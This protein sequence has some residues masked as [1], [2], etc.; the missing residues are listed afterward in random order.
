MPEHLFEVTFK[1]S[2][3]LARASEPVTFGVPLARGVLNDAARVQMTDAG[4][5]P[6]LC[7]ATPLAQWPDG[8]IKWMLV[9]TQVPVAAAGEALCLGQL[10]AGE[11]SAKAT[12]KRA[13]VEVVST[14]AGLSIKTG[15]CQ[16][17]LKSGG[18]LELG[19]CLSL[20]GKRVGAEP[21]IEVTL[22]DEAGK[23]CDAAIE[24]WR[25]ELHNRLRA[26]I[27]YE[28]RFTSGGQKLP[29]RYI[30]RLHFFAGLGSV[31]AD[32]TLWNP[33]PAEHPGGVWDL[34][35]KGS[36]YFKELSLK[37]RLQDPST[38]RYST[39]PGG[40]L[41]DSSR[42]VSV[43]QEASGGEN[44][45]SRNHLNRHGETPLRF[46]GYEVRSGGN[47]IERGKRCTPAATLANDELAVSA[48]IT[49]FWQ[50]FPKA[51]EI[52]DDTLVT[53]LFPG[54]FPDNF[55]LQGGE[56][57][58]HTVYFHFGAGSEVTGG[59]LSW[60]HAPLLP[61]LS[62]QHYFASG[63]CPK[64]VP[65][66]VTATDSYADLWQKMVNV[67]IEPG[68]S[69]FDRR[70]IIDEYGWRNFGDLY[71]DH[72][73]V[74]HKGSGEFVSHYNNQYDVIKGSLIQFMR[75][76]EPAWFRLAGELARHVMDIDI[77]HTE[78]DRY[79]YNYGLFWHTDHHLDA[80]TGSHRT[81]SKKHW[82]S[83]PRHL[84]G[85]G[86]APAHN[87][88]T[89]LLYYHWLTG[90]PMA[91]ECVLSLARFAV[92]GVNGPDKVREAAIEKA[93]TIVKW[94]RGK[95][96]PQGGGFQQVYGLDGPGRGS[97]NS[98]QVLLDAY[99]LSSEKRY[100]DQAER[101]IR[102][103][104]SPDDD[105]EARDLLNAEI[106]WM[107]TIFLQALGRY[108]DVK[109]EAGEMDEAFGYARSVLLKYAAWMLENEYPYLE[110]PEKL[111]FPN[112]T[113]SAQEI[114]KSDVLAHA[115]LYAPS[116]LRGELL[117]KSSF[118]FQECLM[119]LSAAPT[120]ELTRVVVL[121]MTNGMTHLDAIHCR[122]YRR[123]EAG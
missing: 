69:F 98:L 123:N 18:N 56:K 45:R 84:V 94:V 4:G 107:Y 74:F 80:G 27:C 15:A 71:A 57:K 118:F 120:R 9:D 77:Y 23:P 10:A 17:E 93:K 67:A 32:L 97:G 31:R 8:S 24:Q 26:V 95:L 29:L 60:V 83:K 50:N 72:E 54:E 25:V 6:L 41:S 103:C 104:V 88:A 87:Y 114:R 117:G 122:H 105:I 68:N 108:C 48:T 34:G 21:A 89:G 100:L 99:L 62:A 96:K 86:P 16:F 14:T 49:H 79:Q 116:P 40:P 44:W 66:T 65:P 7:A 37:V 55:E 61:V 43:Y 75:T 76:G 112:E 121:L 85:G 19:R 38:G 70:E 115:A 106:R 52:R 46:N 39:Q 82:E 64:P 90:D 109:R 91:K 78:R 28:G 92:N 33:Q 59:E 30:C 73:A 12:E 47:V 63:A 110:K 51:L 111:E 1:E 3:G 102:R 113:W 119:Q 81:H 101:L 42:E 35:G 36:I 58:T 22:F 13:G 53:N 20:D 2:A 5:S 11:S